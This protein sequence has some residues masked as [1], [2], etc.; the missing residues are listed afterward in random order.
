M[1]PEI[2]DQILRRIDTNDGSIRRLR[3][4]VYEIEAILNAEDWQPADSE[5]MGSAWGVLDT[6]YAIAVTQKWSELDAS[7]QHE[8][9]E[10]LAVI[11]PIIEKGP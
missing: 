11:R 8:I 1:Q 10:A 3:T 7:C 4:L 2:R 9:N 6:V 5:R